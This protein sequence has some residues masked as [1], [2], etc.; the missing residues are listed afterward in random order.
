MGSLAIAT[1]T[2]RSS[3]AGRDGTVSVTRG[4]GLNRW[5]AMTPAAPLVAGNGVWPVSSRYSVQPSE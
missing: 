1:A 5:A 4:G 2:T 3:A